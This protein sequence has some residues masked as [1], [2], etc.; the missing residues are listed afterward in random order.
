M[1]TTALVHYIGATEK[2]RSVVASLAADLRDAG[3]EVCVVDISDTT[4]ISQDFPPSW[5]VRVLG[6]HIT[7]RGLLAVLESL[8]VTYVRPALL[9]PPL[10]IRSAHHEA[11]T[12]ALESELLTYFRLDF[13]P[14]TRE[15]RVLSHRLRVAM[16]RTY[17]A[18][19]ELWSQNPPA[20]VLVPNGRTSRQKAA[21]LVAEHHGIPVGFYENGR[22]TPDHYYLGTT[23]PHDRLASQAEVKSVV[24]S[25]EPGHAAELADSWITHRMSGDDGTNRFS[26]GWAQPKGAF[27]QGGPGQ[28]AVFFSSSFDEYRAFGPMWSIDGWSHQFEA[29]DAMMTILEGQGVGLVL[30]LHP[31]LGTKSRAYFQREVTDVVDL[32]SRH[33]TLVLHW[34]NSEVN[35]YDLVRQADY[36]IVERSTIGLEAILMGKPVWV[37]QASQ[38]DQVADVRQVLSPADITGDIM[39]PWKVSR[40]GAQSFAAYWMVQEHPLRWGWSTWST[41]NPSKAPLRMKI[42]MLATKNPWSHRARLVRT[43]WTARRNS[44][45]SPPRQTTESQ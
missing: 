16:E 35:S 27:A 10:A 9:P 17:A 23:Q 5:L 38:W 2:S 31:N 15:A 6:H 19:D 37:T 8:G 18:L 32:Q 20:R 12:Q 43:E 3:Q 36:V 4:V 30:R 44:K 33:P 21:R 28:K 7:P 24:A 40:V 13:I 25:L 29:F 22:A 42:A 11:L 41:W 45:F 26:S 34:H 39:R 1:T 14:S